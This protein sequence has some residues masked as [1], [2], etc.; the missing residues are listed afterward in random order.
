MIPTEEEEKAAGAF[1]DRLIKEGL[2]SIKDQKDQNSNSD[3]DSK[4]ESQTS[5]SFS[6]KREAIKAVLS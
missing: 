5:L 4:E 3:T 6:S 1:V 2:I